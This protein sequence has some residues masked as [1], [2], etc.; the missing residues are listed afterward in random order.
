[1]RK[2]P[3]PGEG[4]DDLSRLL[5]DLL[6]FLCLSLGSMRIVRDW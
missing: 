3:D 4:K 6:I 1:M 2:D 5:E